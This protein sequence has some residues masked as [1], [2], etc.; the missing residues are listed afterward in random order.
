MTADD[1]DDERGCSPEDAE[2]D[3]EDREN[4][5]KGVCHEWGGRR[6]GHGA[7]DSWCHCLSHKL[8][9][10]WPGAIQNSKG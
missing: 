6:E 10:T 2:W 5:G 4:W 1:K 9:V 8:D 3:E 7:G